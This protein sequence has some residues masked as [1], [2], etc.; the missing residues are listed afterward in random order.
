MAWIAEL[1]PKQQ[2]R[3]E[4]M[5]RYEEDSGK[6]LAVLQTK[7]EAWGGKERLHSSTC[8]DLEPG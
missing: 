4:F 8:G 6:R 3:L 7:D 1:H 5:R 2:V